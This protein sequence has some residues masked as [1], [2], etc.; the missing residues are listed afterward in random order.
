MA[1][2]FLIGRIVLGIYYV[3]SGY[4][5]F[6]NLDFMAG[7]SASK[8]VPAPKLAVIGTGLMLVIGGLSVLLGIQPYLGALL[9]V[10]FLI[11]TAI[12]MH[13][14]W[15]VSDP[16]MRMGELINFEKDLALAASALMFLAIP[17][18]WAFSLGM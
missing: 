10:V 8:G 15:T 5:H 14:F 6:K 11:P 13:N 2:A 17:A 4:N 12:M 9:L 7:Y 3:Y 18:P 1:T 16:Q